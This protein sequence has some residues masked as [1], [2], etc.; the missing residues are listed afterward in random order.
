[1]SKTIYYLGAGASY[2]KRND[3]G[4]VLEGLPVVAEIPSQIDAFRV[5][6]EKAETP[7]D[8]VYTFHGFINVTG[9]SIADEKQYLLDAID[10][11]RDRIREH[12]T[13]D[14][15]ARKLYLI[16]DKYTFEIVKNVWC[17]FFIWVQIQHKPDGRYDTF[18]ANVLD[19][20]TMSLPK[21]ISI[22]S[23]NYDSQI[24]I[25]Y[26]AYR[27]DIELLILEKNIQ[28]EWPSL[29]ANGRIFKVNGS[30]TFANRSVIHSILT[31]KKI[32]L[33][34]QLIHYYYYVSTDTSQL[35]IQFKTHL[36][37]AWESSA[38]QKNMMDTIDAT[39]SDTELIVVIGY[40]FP[41]FNREVDRSIFKMMPH[42]RKV[43]IQ[44]KNPVAVSQSI[45]AVLP[46]GSMIKIVPIPD[47]SQ[48]LQ[49]SEHDHPVSRPK[50]Q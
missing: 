23:W 3:A 26:Q 19:A 42:L 34:I 49:N 24:E 35:G 9:K 39:V 44:D 20:K 38:N 33:S 12:A 45:E 43:Y 37:F 1:M 21:D 28:G 15:F 18:L 8:A 41:Y 25:A 36:S 50:I 16:G 2:G 40:S 30:A 4:E 6:I 48:F 47:C 17:V 32:P 22:I 13:I 14:T 46:P 27:N 7:L 31:N 5:F 10:E 29:P 11:L